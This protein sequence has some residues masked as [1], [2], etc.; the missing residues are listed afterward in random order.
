MRWVVIRVFVPLLIIV[1]ACSDTGDGDA[2]PTGSL[3][4]PSGAGCA[5]VTGV[6]VKEEGDGGYRFD[7]TVRSAD[8]GWDKYADGWEVRSPDGTVLGFR[9]LLHPHET[10]QPFTR[11]L[12]GV[13]VPAT[14]TAVTVAARDSV[15]GYCGQEATVELPGRS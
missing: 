7:V 1:S 15:L 13:E 12:S 5:D 8:T 9:E 14:V 4:A 10:E 2:A 6:V 11:S 3:T